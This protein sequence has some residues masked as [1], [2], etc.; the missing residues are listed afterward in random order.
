M[1]DTDTTQHDSEDSETSTDSI[2]KPRAR[3]LTDQRHGLR[4]MVWKFLTVQ[5]MGTCL[6]NVAVAYQIVMGVFVILLFVVDRRTSP[7]VTTVDVHA[8][9][10]VLFG[11]WTVEYVLRVWCCVEERVSELSEGMST[12]STKDRCIERLRILIHPLMIFDLLALAALLVDIIISQN[13]FRGIM[14]LRLLSLCRIERDFQIVGPVLGVVFKKR[15]ML[16]ASMALVIV[17][18]VVASVCMFYIESAAPEPQEAGLNEQF[19]PDHF[20]TIADCMWWACI[21]MSTVGYGDR[22]PRTGLGRLFAAVTALLAPALIALP[23]GI[24][25]SGF[26]EELSEKRALGEE[27]AQDESLGQAVEDVLDRAGLTSGRISER[28]GATLQR[29][30]AV[31]AEVAALRAEL[32]E[33]TAAL[34]SSGQAGKP[35]T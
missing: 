28:Y 11:I 34:V 10:M 3:R 22:V 12:L 14:A 32:R 8:M 6:T 19:D 24:I 17:M 7:D 5:G 29:A 15:E 21:T 2:S 35:P 30:D 16:A 9:Q 18:I 13:S 4:R 31:E 1:L 20:G 26:Q 27:S 33:L 23:A 25:A